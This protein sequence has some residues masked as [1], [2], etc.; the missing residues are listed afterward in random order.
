MSDSSK[1]VEKCDKKKCDCE[2]CEQKHHEWCKEDA[3]CDGK[4]KCQK[5][6]II[7]TKIYHEYECSKPVTTVT[8]WGHTTH[9]HTETK[10]CDWEKH[11]KEPMPDCCKKCK[12]EHCGCDKK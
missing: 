5:R 12:K 9:G 11:D 7:K 6:R 1:S 2:K 10:V 4:V 3:P 8:R